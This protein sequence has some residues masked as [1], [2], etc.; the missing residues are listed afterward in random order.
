MVLDSA[1]VSL[2]VQHLYNCTHENLE[3]QRHLQVGIVL[4]L[5]PKEF[6]PQVRKTLTLWE[7]RSLCGTKPS[8]ACDPV[9]NLSESHLTLGLL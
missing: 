2:C 3:A 6:T 9:T 4:I 7:A 8:F 5:A 1:S